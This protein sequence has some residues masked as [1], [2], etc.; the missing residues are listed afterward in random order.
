MDLEIHDRNNSKGNGEGAQRPDQQRKADHQFDLE[1][2]EL[3]TA[4]KADQV[5]I[6]RTHPQIEPVQDAYSGDPLSYELAFQ[7]AV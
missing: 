6:D 7:V 2:D 1:F 3:Q 4:P 5:F